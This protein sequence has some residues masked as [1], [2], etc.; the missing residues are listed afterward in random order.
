MNTL[1]TAAIAL[2][3]VYLALRA[4]G[5]KKREALYI[6]ATMVQFNDGE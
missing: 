3:E 4:A 6:I 5:F 2:H 1:D